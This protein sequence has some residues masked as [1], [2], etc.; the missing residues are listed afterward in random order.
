[1]QSIPKR[2]YIEHPVRVQGQS[3]DRALWPYRGVM[4]LGALC[5][6]MAVVLGIWRIAIT[7]GFLLPPIP[8][9]IPVHGHIMIGGF[10]AALIIFERMIA[11]RIHGLIW[12]P[13]VYVFSSLFLQT[14][15]PMVR[16]LHLIAL[17]GWILH[18]WMSYKTFH[19][20]EKP[21]VESIAFIVLSF[22]L[23]S[24]G[25][26]SARIEVGLSALAFPIAVIAIERLELSM[27]FKKTGARIVLFGLIGWCVLWIVSTWR[28][29]PNLSAMGIVTLILT[30]FL[31]FYDLSLRTRTS[32]SAHNLHGFLKLALIFAYLWLFAGSIVMVFWFTISGAILKDILFHLFG[33]GFIFTMILGHAPLILPAAL[34]KMPPNKAPLIPFL[35]F[36]AATLIRIVGDF[37]LMQSVLLWQ[38][39]GWITGVVSAL[40]FFIYLVTLFFSLKRKVPG[41][42]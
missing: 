26:L 18:R 10:L 8:E 25:G 33:L 29:I 41:K 19:R 14:Q 4:V 11:L 32:K 35:I 1:M 24:S 3:K 7:R 5:F 28:G 2:I 34:G 17:V 9:W 37:A 21:V 40:A 39:T 42:A 30:C 36:Q 22:A 13:Y 15:A 16:L 6:L 20:W 27:Q 12:V 23:L 38:W 31:A